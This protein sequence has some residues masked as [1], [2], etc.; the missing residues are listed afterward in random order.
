MVYLHRLPLLSSTSISVT[1]DESHGHKLKVE[2]RIKPWHMRYHSCIMERHWAGE[3][4]YRVAL[5]LDCSFN[6]IFMSLQIE[7]T[8]W[9]SAKH[10]MGMAFNRELWNRIHKCR[11]HFCNFDDYNWDWSLEH[12]SNNCI[13]DGLQVLLLKGPRVFHIGEW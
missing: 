5:F 6:L 8:K 3:M 1:F 2:L 4:V 13:K 9:V 7:L 11:E 12:I 10:N